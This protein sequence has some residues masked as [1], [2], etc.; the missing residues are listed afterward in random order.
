SRADASPSEPSRS[1]TIE[2]FLV[3][4][5]S[6][7]SEHAA[8]PFADD[9]SSFASNSRSILQ[10]ENEG[11]LQLQTLAQNPSME[12]WRRIMSLLTRT[13]EVYQD[14]PPRLFVV[15]PLDSEQWD[16][17]NPS[18]TRLKLYFICECW[19][20]QAVEGT[21]CIHFIKHQGYDVV[22]PLEFLKRF[23][24]Y[25]RTVHE[26]IKPCISPRFPITVPDL[27][28]MVNAEMFNETDIDENEVADYVGLGMEKVNDYIDKAPQEFETSTL[29]TILGLKTF[30]RRKD[31]GTWGNMYRMVTNGSVS[32]VCKRH[33]RNETTDII[34]A[35]NS[36]SWFN[37]ALSTVDAVFKT[38]EEAEMLYS[39]LEKTKAI[40]DLK[41]KLDWNT[42]HKDYKRLRDVLRRTDISIFKLCFGDNRK[43]PSSTLYYG[44][45]YT[46]I[47]DMMQQSSIRSFTLESVPTDFF[48]QSSLTSRDHDFTNLRHLELDLMSVDQIAS[49]LESVMAKAPNLN[50]LV[51]SMYMSMVPTAYSTMMR[52]QTCPILFKCQSMRILTPQEYAR[53]C[54]ASPRPVH[55][56][57]KLAHMFRAHGDRIETLY[58]DPEWMDDGALIALAD[59]IQDESK[60]K[61]LYL[62]SAKDLTCV[63]H[64]S[65][66]VAQSRLHKF[67]LSFEEHS[68]RQRILESIQWS[69]IRD[70]RITQNT[71]SYQPCSSKLKDVLRHLVKSKERLVSEPIDLE[72]FKLDIK[73]RV[74]ETEANLLQLVLSSSK[75]KHLEL[76]M[77][78]NG[79]QVLALLKCIDVS[80]LEYFEACPNYMQP[81]TVQAILDVLEHAHQLQ[82]VCLRNATILPKQ[83][84]LMLAKGV[85]LSAG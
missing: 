25:I 7:T 31:E 61:T 41:I 82:V 28:L 44:R 50:S 65:S 4:P 24:T 17:L 6:E 71:S 35:L 81:P 76:I 33:S 64:V 53:R 16:P 69:H 48:T 68:G 3:V 27:P 39:A 79:V 38:R 1:D 60:L 22:N 57:R 11:H 70:L 10:T 36:P 54:S 34:S 18:T 84:E 72:H 30:L 12:I 15:I 46:P 2:E 67:E 29:P 13:Y 83:R 37:G 78:S 77:W 51:L 21:P 63:D 8:V 42:D 66:I 40:C 32:W 49:G 9:S 62:T 56:F 73:F 74:D 20:H 47:I 58:I 19:N 52:Y 75:P 5:V 14:P 26:F 55:M 59:A 85:H 45:L 43:P 80:R 23:A